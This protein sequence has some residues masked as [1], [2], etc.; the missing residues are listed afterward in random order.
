MWIW[1]LADETFSEYDRKSE[2]GRW[3][4]GRPRKK[5]AEKGVLLASFRQESTADRGSMV[6]WKLWGIRARTDEMDLRRI[7]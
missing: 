1:P 3:E 4:N 6:G 5:K 2:S 7:F